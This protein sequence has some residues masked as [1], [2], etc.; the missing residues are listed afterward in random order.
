MECCGRSGPHGGCRSQNGCVRT[1]TRVAAALTRTGSPR[2]PDARCCALL[3]V[4]L[5]MGPVTGRHGRSG[6]CVHAV[7]IHHHASGFCRPCARDRVALIG[8]PC[9][10][11][12]VSVPSADTA[13]SVSACLRKRYARHTERSRSHTRHYDGQNCPVHIGSP[14]VRCTIASRQPHIR[15]QRGSGCTAGARNAAL[16]ISHAR[17]T[18]K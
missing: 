9:R 10:C 16:P 12:T 14:G 18:C 3:R 15:G 2:E 13:L 11:S 4:R 6:R 1:A 8:H 17:I 7:L 5:G